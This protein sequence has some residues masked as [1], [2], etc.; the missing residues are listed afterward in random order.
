MIKNQDK[1]LNRNQI[2]KFYTKKE[3]V[4]LCFDNIKKNLNINKNNDFIIEPSCGNG[5]FI[6]IIKKLG[7]NYMF[8]DIEPENNEIIKQDYLN[9]VYYSDK[10][11][12]LHIIGNP[13]FGRQSTLAIKFIKHSCKFCDT[14]SFILPK[15]FKKDSMKKHFPLNFHLLKEF[16]LPNKSFLLNEIE[17]DVPCIFQI[18]QKKYELRAE[19]IKLKPN[20]FTFVKKNEEPDMAFRRVGGK[21][22]NISKEIED[23]SEQSHYFLKVNENIDEFIKI[24]ENIKF[25]DNNT[26]GPKSISKQE[27][28]REINNIL[29]K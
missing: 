16:D 22:G 13:P 7:N 6:E 24:I 29:S 3:I 2:D 21:A 26:V 1:G 18:W 20:N 11:S 14:I 5:S 23:K 4:E 9:Y 15:S 28:I 27:L 8:L 17:C 12:K 10:Y 25:E 19:Y